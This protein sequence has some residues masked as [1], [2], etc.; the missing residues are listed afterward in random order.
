MFRA[1]N[2]RK[3]CRKPLIQKGCIERI[4]PQASTTTLNGAR[5]P[6]TE[7]IRDMTVTDITLAAFTALQQRSHCRLRP[8]ITRVAADQGGAQAI[9]FTTWAL[10]LLSNASAVAC[11]LI[12]KDDRAMAE[13]ETIFRGR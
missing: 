9:S 11:A 12:D 13:P 2:S 5:H 8:Q 10:F 4:C 7:D 1:S 6:E 3:S